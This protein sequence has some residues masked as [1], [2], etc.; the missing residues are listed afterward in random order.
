[1]NRQ[2]G[3]YI[4][5]MQHNHQHVGKTGHAYLWEDVLL[6]SVHR[7]QVDV[8]LEVSQQGQA[9]VNVVHMEDT[10]HFRDNISPEE[11]LW[12]DWV[13]SFIPEFI[14]LPESCQ[15]VSKLLF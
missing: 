11:L 13:Q 4:N 7:K 1:M 5:L 6:Q 14:R 3:L 8:R 10:E 12:Q 15:Q 2:M 9:D